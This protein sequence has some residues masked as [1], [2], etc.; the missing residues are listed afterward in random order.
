MTATKLC[1][2]NRPILW[3]I[4]VAAVLFALATSGCKTSAAPAG[5]PAAQA[6]PAPVASTSMLDRLPAPVREKFVKDREGATVQRV[7]HRLY[8][9]GVVHYMISSTDAK[10]VHHED[11]YRADGVLVS[12]PD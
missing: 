11:E 3:Q 8:P 5:A 7:K 6:A 10:G 12:K 4:V 9:D 1:P 2:T